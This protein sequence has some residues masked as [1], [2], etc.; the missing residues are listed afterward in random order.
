MNH[1]ERLNG[2][3]IANGL[4]PLSGRLNPGDYCGY[5]LDLVCIELGLLKPEDIM[6]ER[7]RVWR[8][9]L[10]RAASP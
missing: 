7:K 3:A 9:I 6:A 4:P 8:D 1:R 5:A 2:V 10:D